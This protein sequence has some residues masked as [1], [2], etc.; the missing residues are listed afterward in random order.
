MLRYVAQLSCRVQSAA[1]TSD[2]GLFPFS[3]PLPQ[4]SFSVIFYVHATWKLWHRCTRTDSPTDR[5]PAKSAARTRAGARF[6][7]WL[8]RNL[9]D[10]AARALLPGRPVSLS[11]DGT[12]V[13]EG[14]KPP[15]VGVIEPLCWQGKLQLYSDLQSGLKA[16]WLEKAGKELFRSSRKKKSGV[17]MS[18]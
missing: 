14:R 5:R 11:F 4:N 2:V 16:V 3:S 15:V 6:S 18:S 9:V 17:V 10:A 12:A 8:Y 13:R 7:S 1:C